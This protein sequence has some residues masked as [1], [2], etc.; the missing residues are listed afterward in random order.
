MIRR[1]GPLLLLIHLGTAAS[2]AA[3]DT[4]RAPAVVPSNYD[5]YGTG[6][7][8]SFELRSNLVTR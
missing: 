4:A 6:F 1:L 5:R 3:Q 2:L 7:R 8:D